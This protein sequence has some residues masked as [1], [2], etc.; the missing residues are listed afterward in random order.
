MPTL[1]RTARQTTGCPLGTEERRILSG[2]GRREEL[3]DICFRNSKPGDIKHIDQNGDNV[4]D[5]KDE[6][7]LGK[8]GWYGSPM[9]LGINLTAKWRSITFAL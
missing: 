4:I 6:V 5:P 9:T 3:A 7:Y 1:T 8:G 2:R